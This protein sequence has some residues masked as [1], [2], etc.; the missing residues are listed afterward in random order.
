MDASGLLTVLAVLLTGAT[1]LP[2]RTRLDLRIRITKVN[3][4]IFYILGASSLYLL[5]LDV[6]KANN[7]SLP[8]DWVFGFDKHSSL[9]AISLLLFVGIIIKLKETKL[10]KSSVCFLRETIE[11]LLKDGNFKDISYLINKYDD[12]LIDY[13]HHRPWYVKLHDKIKPDFNGL[14]LIQVDS[15]KNSKLKKKYFYFREKVAS[16][17]ISSYWV[18]DNSRKILI[19]IFKSRPL[20]KYLADN[21]PV[22]ALKLLSTDLGVE[23]LQRDEFITFLIEDP[24]S[25]FYRELSLCQYLSSSDCYEIE[26]SNQLLTYLFSDI[27]ILEDLKIYKPIKEYIVKFIK[28]E[29]KKTSKYHKKGDDYTFNS[30]NVTCPIYMT[31]FFFDLM[32]REAID[33]RSKNHLFPNYIYQISKEIFNNIEHDDEVNQDVEFI[34]FPTRYDYLLYECFSATCHWL[35]MI[36]DRKK[37]KSTGSYDPYLIVESIG[38]MLYVVLKSDKFDLERKAYYLGIVLRTICSLDES[39]LTAYSKKITEISVSQY[40][41]SECNL[42]EMVHQMKPFLKQDEWEFQFIIDKYYLTS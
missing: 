2:E 21:Y 31:I 12:Q 3:K 1:L 10:P 5:F 36:V 34:E 24:H 26:P 37:D 6:L 30:E 7:L 9:L 38:K 41:T 15:K 23:L 40:K 11:Q 39:G 8:F 22:V 13:I 19:S 25:P 35:S 32:I 42:I 18:A 28:S 17:M 33:K 20:T 16:K 14:L 4:F 27:D 29:N